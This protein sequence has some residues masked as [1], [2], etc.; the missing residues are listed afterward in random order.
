MNKNS[1]LHKHGL[2]SIPDTHAFTTYTSAT[3]GTAHMCP[4]ENHYS[5]ARWSFLQCLLSTGGFPD[6]C[7]SPM[8]FFLLYFIFEPCQRTNG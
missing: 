3:S 8:P 7:G 1:N 6:E 5:N 4:T 2:K